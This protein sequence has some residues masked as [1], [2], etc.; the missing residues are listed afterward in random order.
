MEKGVNASDGL[1]YTRSMGVVYEPRPHLRTHHTPTEMNLKTVFKATSKIMDS[2]R[3]VFNVEIQKKKY[4]KA[5]LAHSM[6]FFFTD[7]HKLN[8]KEV[9]ACWLQ[10]TQTFMEVCISYLEAVVEDDGKLQDPNRGLIKAMKSVV[11]K[12]GWRAYTPNFSSPRAFFQA[13]HSCRMVYFLLQTGVL[14]HLLKQVA[15]E[16]QSPVPLSHFAWVL[17]TIT[18][19][20]HGD[21]DLDEVE[22]CAIVLCQWL[23]EDAVFKDLTATQEQQVS[24]KAVLEAMAELFADVFPSRNASLVDAAFTLMERLIELT[25]DIMGKYKGKAW[26][27]AI[28]F[29][30]G[31]FLSRVEPA[32]LPF[33]TIITERRAKLFLQF[34]VYNSP[35]L[36]SW[37][38]DHYDEVF[39]DEGFY[40]F[41]LEQCVNDSRVSLTQMEHLFIIAGKNKGNVLLTIRPLRLACRFLLTM[42]P[43]ALNEQQKTRFMASAKELVDT[44]WGLDMSLGDFLLHEFFMRDEKSRFPV[45]HI[46]RFAAK[47][48]EVMEPVKPV[49]KNHEAFQKLFYSHETHVCVLFLAT[50]WM[51]QHTRKEVMML[52]NT[53]HHFEKVLQFICAMKRIL[54]DAQ[55]IE[56]EAL[57]VYSECVVQVA[58]KQG[59]A[60]IEVYSPL[61]T[62]LSTTLHR[63]ET[64]K[65]ADRRRLK[66][67]EK[68]VVKEMSNLNKVWET[69]ERKRNYETDKESRKRQVVE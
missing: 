1:L 57:K 29:S 46:L 68:T 4:E 19:L 24:L 39:T 5:F 52:L 41:M 21:V 28:P 14:A 23:K 66:A 54:C 69:K 6:L 62:L 58:Q 35:A 15:H 32:K 56:A 30:L 37:I 47:S 43:R 36:F 40:Q 64:L 55:S 61:F 33:S 8:R 13:I 31:C 65:R 2:Q 50:E 12:K 60:S 17:S 44:L 27:K 45:H 7:T 34:H 38:E 67:W 49:L 3:P 25:A 59:Q 26:E 10:D 16:K 9:A 22:R 51:I 11:R 42:K 53:E 18:D 48:G 20:S 63:V